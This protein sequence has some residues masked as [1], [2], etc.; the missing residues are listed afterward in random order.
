M[1]SLPR[2]PRTP[3]LISP[4]KIPAVPLPGPNSLWALPQVRVTRS[5][6]ARMSGSSRESTASSHRMSF[7]LT[8]QPEKSGGWKTPETASD[9]V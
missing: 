8:C 2:S 3:A 7:G 6:M 9:A 1:S 4:A 5:M